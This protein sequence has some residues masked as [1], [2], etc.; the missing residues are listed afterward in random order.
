MTRSIARAGSKLLPVTGLTV[1]G[2]TVTVLAVTG[3]TVTGLAVLAPL[4]AAHAAPAGV[5]VT[6]GHPAPAPSFAGLVGHRLFAAPFGV[7]AGRGGDV[8]VADTGANRIEEFGP[9]GDLR[10]VGAAGLDEPEG[11]AVG[12]AGDVWV[13]DTGA[14]R[15]VEFSG[16]GRRILA[17]GSTGSGRGR[18]DQPVAVAVAGRVVYVADQLNNRIE[19]FS[20]AGRYLA[21]ISVPTPA[22]VAIG[23]RGD[24]WV[25]SPGSD[26]GD[27]IYEFNGRGA[28]VNSFGTIQ[29]GYGDLGDTAGIAVGP[30]GRIYVAQ[31]DYGFVTVFNPGGTFYT[32]FGLHT[33]GDQNLR[34]PQAI[35]LGPDGEIYVADSGTGAVAR[36]A[37]P[38]AMRGS[39]AG[40]R[41]AAAGN[42]GAMSGGPSLPLIIGLSVLAF[43]LAAVGLGW[44]LAIR[45][46]GPADGHGE[47]AAPA[48][49]KPFAA[50]QQRI[51]QAGISRRGLLVSAT[52]LSGTALTGTALSGTALAGI[53]AAGALPLS[54]R[55]QLT[56]ALN[57]PPQGGLSSIEHIVILMQE[58]RSFDHYFG[59][60]PGVR[61]FS[62][63]AALTL[64]TGR[65][66]FHQPDPGHAQGYLTPFHYDTRSTSAQATPGTDHTWPTQH[67]AWNNGKMDQWVKA[68]GPYTMGYFTEQ[69]IPFQWAL[70]EAFTLCDNYHCSVFGPT[71]PNRLYLWTGMIDPSGTG[72][73]P[74]TDDSPAFDNVILSWT[75]YPER[76]SKAGITWQ[77]Y[78][79]EDNYDDNALAWFKQIAYAPA[80]SDLYQRAMTKRPAGWFEAD[81]R[82]GTLPQVSWIV[83]PTAQSEHPDYFP[84]A[85][86]EYVASKL[87]ALASNPDLW[88]KTLFILTY[89]ENDGMFDHVPPP[90]APAGTAGEYVSGEPIGLGFRVPCTLISPWTAGGQIYSPVL[91]HTSLIQI[92]E[93]VFGVTE[94]NISPWRRQTCDD[95]TGA[96][97]FG[98]Q[99]SYPATNQA[100]SLAAAEAQ[101]LTAQAEVFSNP[102]PAIPSANEPVPG[103]GQG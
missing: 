2:L 65:S 21:S 30:D 80:S 94:P 54:L 81:A 27:T 87:D 25:S 41:A 76:L 98:P 13:A 45:R 96:L 1:T 24:I 93:Q 20:T 90:T 68:K 39:A 83:A 84:A 66:V 14:D 7:A 23:A 43:L 71:N 49:A 35:A 56:A 85:G 22:G 72:G 4:T 28:Q 63:P 75:T 58:N 51:T 6:G 88:S 12:R 9:G 26:A 97:Q 42:H 50:V 8:W 34:N 40:I 52:A 10:A 101:L 60:F 102:T 69:D 61:G 100:I 59:T 5:T 95:F 46:R 44:W 18:L 38:A 92:I 67:Q 32:E 16:T 17:F 19:E 36:F 82:A 11:I 37:P 47:P 79:E 3:L 53:G 74:V 89:D 48:G 15:V 103:Q 55:R 70:A 62:D 77:V 64:S 86:A 99:A 29:A 31:P 33:D 91:D 57:S 78:Q 73:G